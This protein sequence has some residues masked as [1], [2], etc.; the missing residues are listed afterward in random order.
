MLARPAGIKIWILNL[1]R[2]IDEGWNGELP[3]TT[4][5]EE[6]KIPTTTTAVEHGIIDVKA[7]ATNHTL[8]DHT[9]VLKHFFDSGVPIITQEE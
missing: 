8:L 6:L 3:R 5:E 4:Y 2:L 1:G 7:I 9:G